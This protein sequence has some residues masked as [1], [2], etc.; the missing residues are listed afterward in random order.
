[1]EYNKED[2][3]QW[4]CGFY[5]GEGWIS[6]DIGNN[7]RTRLGIAQND[8]TPLDI[9]M[10]LWGGA[11]RKRVRKSIASNKI[12]TGY[13]WVLP[14]VKSLEFIKD[15]RP[16]MMIPQ[17]IAQVDRVLNKFKHGEKQEYKCKSCDIYYAS[18]SG[19]RRH[20]KQVHQ[21]IDTSAAAA[22]QENENVEAS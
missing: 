10:K 8:R 6:N 4:F 22:T 16:F 9:G 21:T 7:N 15:I 13:E 2:V 5:E 20:Y 18:P 17:K 19:R 11:I 1:M 3:L 12:C 14:H